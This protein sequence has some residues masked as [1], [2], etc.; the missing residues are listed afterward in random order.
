MSDVVGSKIG[1]VPAN[2]CRLLKNLLDAGSVKSIKCRST[3]DKPRRSTLVPPNQA[4]RK[5]VNG[6]KDKRGGGVVL[7]CRY[8]LNVD[9]HRRSSVMREVEEF[10]ED[11]DGDEA[12][13]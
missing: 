12:V 1:N 8:I 3:A 9:P 11:Y 13:H 5:S 7:D 6:S 4:F 10:L 2:L